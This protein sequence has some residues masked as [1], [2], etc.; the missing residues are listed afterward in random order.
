MLIGSCCG[1]AGEC[2]VGQADRSSR[3]DGWHWRRHWIV[4]SVIRLPVLKV[5]TKAGNLRPE[6]PVLR[7][8]ASRARSE[9]LF[10]NGVLNI[11]Q[12]LVPAWFMVQVVTGNGAC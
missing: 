11:M 6:Q 7:Y 3:V 4:G 5:P 8:H 9:I 1:G 2:G 10:A 12:I